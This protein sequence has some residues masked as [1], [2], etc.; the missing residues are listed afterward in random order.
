MAIETDFDSVV[1]RTCRD[2]RDWWRV[3]AL[4][5]GARPRSPH[6]SVWDVRR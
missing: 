6:G 2:A 1:E 4:L 3:R 5:V